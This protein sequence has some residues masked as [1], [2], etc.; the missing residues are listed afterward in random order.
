MKISDICFA[1]GPHLS[2]IKAASQIFFLA[3][4]GARI[5]ERRKTNI[6]LIMIK[7]KFVQSA[8]ISFP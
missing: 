2:W 1:L 7:K 6:F 8:K 5:Q 4:V 3:F